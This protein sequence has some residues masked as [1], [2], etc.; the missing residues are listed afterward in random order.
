MKLDNN[1]LNEKFEEI[2]VKV[3]FLIE[4]CQ[5]LQSENAELVNRVRELETELGKKDAAQDQ[6]YEQQA[7]VQSKIDGL[8]SKL[9]EFSKDSTFDAQALE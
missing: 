3:D 8:L 7:E 1:L 4:F 5:S 9:R 2:D 6:Y